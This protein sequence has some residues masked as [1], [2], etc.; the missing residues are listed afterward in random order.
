ME[1]E[2]R[3]LSE[4]EIATA[5]REVGGWNLDNGQIFKHFGFDNYLDGVAFASAVGYLAE[6]L[7]HHPDIQIGCPARASSMAISDPE[8][9]APTMS[10]PPGRSWPGFR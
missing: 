7:D 10:A 8:F 4:V 5:L 3:K 1:L 6:K 2:Y 9:P